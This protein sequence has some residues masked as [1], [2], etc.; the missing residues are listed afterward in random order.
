MYG[1]DGSIHTNVRN[2]LVSFLRRL[3]FRSSLFV[4]IFGRTR[5]FNK[6][7]VNNRVLVE[8]KPFIG[9]WLLE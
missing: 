3:H 9:K 8:E 5:R 1:P 4:S 6:R 7:T 2:A